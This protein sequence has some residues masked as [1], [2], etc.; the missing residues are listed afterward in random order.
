MN[1]HRTV[2]RFAVDPFV[3]PYN[4]TNILRGAVRPFN[5]VTNSGPSTRRLILETAPSET[6]FAKSIVTRDG[7]PF[8]AAAPN[9]DYW[10]GEKLRIKY[11]LLPCSAGKIGTVLQAITNTVPTTAVYC[12]PHYTKRQS[13]VAQESDWSSEFSLFLSPTEAVTKG[14]LFIQGNTYYHIRSVPYID[15]AGFLVAPASLLDTPVRTLTLTPTQA[16][17]PAS[18]TT[19]AGTPETVTA[20]VEEAFLAYDNTSE[21]YTTLK[22]GDKTITIKP[23]MT[24]KVG[25]LIGSYKVLSIDVGA[26]GESMCLCRR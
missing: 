19:P 2:E 11:P 5:D 15:G 6:M 7:A 20:F 25:Y 10:R 16:Y 13:V 4:P 26:G 9:P 14:Q 12:Y 24:L 23:I 18:D 21:R 17:S 22:P 8:I 1:L 3:D